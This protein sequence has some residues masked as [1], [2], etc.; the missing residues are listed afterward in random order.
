MQTALM[1]LKK[2]AV[3]K[4]RASRG[5]YWYFGL[6]WF[7][8]FFLLNAVW[9]LGQHLSNDTLIIFGVIAVL[10]F[11]FATVIPIMAVWVRRLHDVGKSGWWAILFQLIP[12]V[13]PLYVYVLTFKKGDTGYNK[14]GADPLT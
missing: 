3:F 14:Y 4:G 9:S 8:V 6:L 7:I 13:G 11:F 12:V 5:E 1:P 2:Y 10:S